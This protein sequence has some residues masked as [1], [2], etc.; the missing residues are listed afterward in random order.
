[1]TISPFL[2]IVATKTNIVTRGTKIVTWGT[3]IVTPLFCTTLWRKREGP[4]GTK[5]VTGGTKTVTKGT[6]IVT[7]FGRKTVTIVTRKTRHNR[8]G[9]PLVGPS[10][11]PA[12]A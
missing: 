5:I 9:E 8:H 12:R 2:Q 3:K 1:M 10:P 7:P 11:G 6:N 4:R